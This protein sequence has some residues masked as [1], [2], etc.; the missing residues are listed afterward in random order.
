VFHRPLGHELKGERGPCSVNAAF[1]LQG[2]GSPATPDRCVWRPYI[3]CCPTTKP[4]FH[5]LI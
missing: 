1:T 4:L 5:W 2:V 3:I